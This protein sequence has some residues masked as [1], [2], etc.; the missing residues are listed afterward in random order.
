MTSEHPPSKIPPES[1]VDARGG[2]GVQIGGRDQINVWHE[3]RLDPVALEILS[4]RVAANQLRQMPSDDAALLLA[5]A[6]VSAS[7]EVLRVLDDGLAIS[8]LTRINR[9]KAEELVRAIA[10]PAARLEQ[11]PAAAEAIAHRETEVRSALGESVGELALA[12]PSPRGT[13]GYYQPFKNGL[14]HWSAQGGAQVT[15][16]AIAEYHNG[17]G[18]S[19]GRLGFPLTPK[20]PA[21]RS[22][23]GTDGSWQRFE[24]SSDSCLPF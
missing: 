11:L 10:S 9:R 1:D 8:L 6:P 3:R 4:P 17:H 20:T 12:T 7:A 23:F 24:S 22:P 18:G 19:G 13:R 2:Q 16:G 21:Q 5:T 14:I 15:M